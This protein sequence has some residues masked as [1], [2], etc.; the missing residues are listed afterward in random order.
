MEM[1][2]WILSDQV[3]TRAFEKAIQQAVRRGDVVV[4]VGAGT[5]L[6]S[7]L[8]CR[9]GAARVYAIEEAP[10]IEM[11][12]ILVLDNGYSD[13]VILL[14]GNSRK[15]VLP[16]MADVVVSETIGAFVFS[17][18]ILSTLV[19]ARERLLKPSGSLI[20]ERIT[21]Y[22][23]PVESYEE[24]IGFWEKPVHG[25]DFS[26]AAPRVAV[27]T[28]IASRKIDGRHFLDQEQVLYDLDFRSAGAKTDFSR[29]LE[30]TAQRK[31]TLHG[32]VGFWEALLFGDASIRCRPG[33]P[34]V[35]WTPVLFRLPEG[36][37]AEAGDLITL[38][39]GR[40]DRPGWSW[41]WNAQ[42]RRRQLSP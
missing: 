39:F 18:G 21:V 4:D 23:A 34:H 24:G 41:R 3:R 38:S 15:I 12:R 2:L 35:H 37:A 16:E 28:M 10:I 26:S 5:G 9:A 22:L 32:F 25:F 19:D 31:G 33:G 40:R 7:L 1:H 29:T 17:E 14:R 20:P 30:F 36:I 8:A 11:A 6:L 42:V 27:E 13:R